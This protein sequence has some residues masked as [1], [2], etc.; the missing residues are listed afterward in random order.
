MCA[1]QSAN[2]AEN[3]VLVVCA[4]DL[5]SSAL[6]LGENVLLSCA[7]MSRPLHRHFGCLPFLVR[8]VAHLLHLSARVGFPSHT[9]PCTHTRTRLDT[10]SKK[11]K[12]THT[13]APNACIV[14]FVSFRFVRCRL[15]RSIPFQSYSGRFFFFFGLRLNPKTDR[16]TKRENHSVGILSWPARIKIKFVVFAQ[17]RLPC[18]STYVMRKV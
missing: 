10:A 15:A 2:T 7:S 3:A 18:G 13:H 1:T 5:S 9:Y 14:I 11:D 8:L 16:N 6:F 17:I 12:C 4:A